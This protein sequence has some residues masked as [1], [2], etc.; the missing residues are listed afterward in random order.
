MV[1]C[2]EPYIQGQDDYRKRIL[3][4]AETFKRTTLY[5]EYIPKYCIRKE[6]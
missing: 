2:L 3:Y 4:K 1:V 5:L 6:S